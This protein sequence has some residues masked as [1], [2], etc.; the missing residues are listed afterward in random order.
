MFITTWVS[1]LFLRPL[2]LLVMNIV[3]TTLIAEIWED[4]STATMK[5][6]KWA[7]NTKCSHWF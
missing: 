3:L 4:N 1:F 5:S 6:D 2:F 7:I